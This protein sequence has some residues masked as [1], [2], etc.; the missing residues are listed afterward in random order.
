[1]RCDTVLELFDD[2]EGRRAGT[3]L[4]GEVRE[5]LAAC[6]SCEARYA[7]FRDLSS[8][9][10]GMPLTA[11]PDDLANRLDRRIAIGAPIVPSL[12]SSRVRSRRQVVLAAFAVASFAVAAVLGSMWAL[13][14]S[15]RLETSVAVNALPVGQAEDGALSAAL[16]RSC[17]PDS[18]MMRLV[19]G[20]E[21]DVTVSLTSN[22]PMDNAKVHVLLPKGLSFSPKDRRARGDSKVMTLHDNLPR[23]DRNFKVRVRGTRVGK[24][25]VVALVEAGDSVVVSDT[26]VEVGP[27]DDDQERL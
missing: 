11:L 10:N 12:L 21:M 26:T 2:I 18:S 20:K 22:R 23:G 16:A 13:D 17:G 3:C 9:L 24:W 1:M 5:H 7:R 15:P 14:V 4:E 8:S 25:N 27:D 6:A 19:Q